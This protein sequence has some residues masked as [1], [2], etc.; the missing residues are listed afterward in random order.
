METLIINMGSS[1]TTIYRE[2]EGV[3]LKEASLVALTG[4]GRDQTIKA[5]GNRAKR[6]IG[7][8]SSDVQIVSPIF[9]GVISDTDLA[10]SML[11]YFIEKIYGTGVFR[12]KICALMCVPL[13]IGVAEKKAFEKVCYNAKIL[14]VELV[15]NVFCAAVGLDLKVNTPRAVMVVGIGATTTN[16]AVLSLNSVVSG[17]CVCVGGKNIDRAIENE[18][19]DKLKMEIGEDMAERI[20]KEV[21]SLYKNNTLSIEVEGV[22]V[23]TRGVR[24]ETIYSKNIYDILK[25]YYDKILEGVNVVLSSCPP[26]VI[27]DVKNDSIYFYGGSSQI[28]GLDY[29]IKNNLH[30]NLDITDAS[31]DC[32][33]IGAKKLME[34]PKQLENII[35][36]M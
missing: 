18:I 28:T 31:E 29:Y 15:P 8:T 32:E 21:G 22:D 2:G 11:K 14:D 1:T 12:P 13:G 33:I 19:K 24:K 35:R 26:D 27:S 30:M 3:V 5:I 9:E 16:I 34:N 6:M 25:Y 10:S 7:R 23:D 4:A 17:V 36:N 20:K